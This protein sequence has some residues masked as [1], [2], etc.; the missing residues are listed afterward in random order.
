MVQRV[1]QQVETLE[2]QVGIEPTRLPVKSRSLLT[3]DRTWSNVVWA[4]ILTTF[5]LIIGTVKRGP[6]NILVNEVGIEPT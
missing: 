3:T 4:T 5:V 1:H 2:D 6:T